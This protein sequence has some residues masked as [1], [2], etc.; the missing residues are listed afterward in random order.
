MSILLMRRFWIALL[1]PLFIYWFSRGNA[2]G[3]WWL[4][5]PVTAP[6]LIW[7][8]FAYRKNRKEDAD[9]VDWVR[10]QW[11]EQITTEK[12]EFC[13]R[14]YTF[15]ET[16]SGT[17]ISYDPNNDTLWVKKD[18]GA[19]TQISAHGLAFRESHRI[20][21]YTFHCYSDHN[22]YTSFEDAVIVNKTTKERQINLPRRCFVVSGPSAITLFLG[23]RFQFTAASYSSAMP[24]PPFFA[25]TFIILNIIANASLCIFLFN[26]DNVE[27]WHTYLLSTLVCHALI[28]LL[29]IRV[30]KFDIEFRH[31]VKSL[32]R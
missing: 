15:Q 21:K 28:R 20:K 3:V 26:F 8:F 31:L 4:W 30:D 23:P 19:E 9:S 16:F 32:T 1:L 13:G 6:L 14:A 25:A 11:K 2:I 29:N 12:F 5:L 18:D 24:V 7:T 22:A 17:V 27:L 10:Q